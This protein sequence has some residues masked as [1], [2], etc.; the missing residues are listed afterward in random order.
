MTQ[1]ISTI[2]SRSC[3]A[4]A[5]C[6]FTL[7]LSAGASAHGDEFNRIDNMAKKIQKKSKLLLKETAD[8]RHTTQYASLVDA[9]THLHEAACH[10]CL[11]YTSPSPR[12]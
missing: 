3:L 9:T 1:A 4:I 12:D 2:A 10:V 5:L 8:Y 6:T 7:V 11:L